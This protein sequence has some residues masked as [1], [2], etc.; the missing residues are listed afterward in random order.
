MPRNRTNSKE[1]T[2]LTLV[3]RPTHIFKTPD[4]SHE[5]TESWIF[6]LMVQTDTQ[7]EIVPVAMK[8]TL[9]RKSQILSSTS[10]TAEGLESTG[11]SNQSAAETRR[12]KQPAETDLLANCY[13]V[14]GTPAIRISAADAMRIEVD[15][16]TG[17]GQTRH[18][19]VLVLPWECINKKQL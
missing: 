7:G 18:G 2:P 12:W 5:N 11:L 4:R 8:V 1:P 16:K 10:Y 3:P 13:F 9:L 14:S 19:C 17:D 6:S 15:A